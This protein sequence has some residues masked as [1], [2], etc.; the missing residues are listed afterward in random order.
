MAIGTTNNRADI[1]M[2]VK[3]LK[4]VTGLKYLGETLSNTDTSTVEDRIRITMATAAMARLIRLWKSSSISLP[5]KYKLNKSFV[6][7]MRDL[8]ASCGQGTYGTD[9]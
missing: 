9:F 5:T 3:K 4:E 2:H 8:Y 1:I 6:G 7:S